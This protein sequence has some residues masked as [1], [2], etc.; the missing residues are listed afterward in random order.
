MGKRGF[1]YF[2]SMIPLIGGDGL[3]RKERGEGRWCSRCHETFYS[4][5]EYTA[6]PVP[7][8]SW[9]ADVDANEW[10]DPDEWKQ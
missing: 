9:S 10:G 5:V 1:I 2:G 4:N 3:M 7:I 6:E 8:I